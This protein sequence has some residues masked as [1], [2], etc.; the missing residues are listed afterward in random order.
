MLE[1]L[2]NKVAELQVLFWNNFIKKWLQHRFFPVNIAK[3]LITVFF[4]EH[5]QWLLLQ[6]LY[7]KAVLKN[8]GNF[9]T[10]YCIGIL[11]IFFSW[12]PR[13]CNFNKIEGPG[14]VFCCE[15]YEIFQNSV[16]QNSDFSWTLRGVAENKCSRN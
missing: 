16:M 14:Q 11:L 3:F 9:T 6:V 15:F 4:I 8:F 13:S 12:R 2:F 10:T 5:L 7:K 1:S